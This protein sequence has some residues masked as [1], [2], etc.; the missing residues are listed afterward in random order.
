MRVIEDNREEIPLYFYF[1][2]CFLRQ[3][4]PRE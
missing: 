3:K 4:T 1:V 2:L